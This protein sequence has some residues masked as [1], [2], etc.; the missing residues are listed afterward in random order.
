MT[1]ANGSLDFLSNEFVVGGNILGMRL[2]SLG[3]VPIVTVPL[4]TSLFDPRRASGD[5]GI[6]RVDSRRANGDTRVRVCRICLESA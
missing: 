3:D 6:D 5:T 2:A 4:R 1:S